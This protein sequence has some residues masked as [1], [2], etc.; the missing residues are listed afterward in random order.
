MKLLGSNKS[1][2]G[3]DENGKNGPHS[4]I[5]AVVLVQCNI[6]IYDYQQNLRVLHTFIANKLFSQLVDISPKNY[7]FKKL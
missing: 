7:V 3:K 4:E 1:K 2:I 5:T 6:V